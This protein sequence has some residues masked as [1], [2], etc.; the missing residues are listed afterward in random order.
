[1]KID[2]SAVNTTENTYFYGNI[3]LNAIIGT[4]EIN[5]PSV[6][7]SNTPFSSTI[8]NYF[9]VTS[10]S[11]MDSNYLLISLPFNY[12]S[13]TDQILEITDFYKLTFTDL[14]GI[15]ING[16][17]ADFPINYLRLQSSQSVS[18]VIDSNTFTIESNYSTYTGGSGGGSTVQIMKIINTI[19]GYPDA[20]NYT[21]KLKKNFN[22]VVRI[23]L[24]ST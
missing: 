19:E 1:L 12:F 13:K 20:N 16:I 15:P 18:Q 22:N 6:I 8:L 24:V 14:F 10:A 9:N 7:D 17:N 21:V 3:P 23:E 4:F 5:L 11:Q 2:I